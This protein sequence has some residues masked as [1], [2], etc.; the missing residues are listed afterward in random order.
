MSLRPF[1]LAF[2]VDDLDAARTFYGGVLG[3]AEG[4]SSSQWIDFDFYGHQIVTH[5][6]DVA[7]HDAAE[8]PV[9]GPSPNRVRCRLAL[10]FGDADF[11][12]RRYSALP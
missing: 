5:L 10:E 1:H 6:V 9:D 2:P 7:S 3:C 11:G 4:R 8:N 12:E